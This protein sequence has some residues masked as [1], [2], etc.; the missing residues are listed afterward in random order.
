MPASRGG[1]SI[2]ALVGTLAVLAVSA[3]R[4]PDASE[5]ALRAVL[6]RER[7]AHLAADAELL[8]STIAD[9]LTVVDA[10]QI[11][12]QA[13]PDV[14]AFFRVYFEGASYTERELPKI[15]SPL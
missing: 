12:R 9:T 3:C 14:E 6:D 1:A 10:G 2:A 15:E 8:T 5:P 7:T 11:T 4:G 13:R